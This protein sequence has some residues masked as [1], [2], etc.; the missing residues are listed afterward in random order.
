MFRPFKKHIRWGCAGFL[1][2]MLSS[3]TVLADDGGD[4]APTGR[5]LYIGLFGGGGGSSIN[6][7]TQLGNALF[8]PSAGG[9]LDVHATGRSN[10]SGVGL[11]GL[12]IGHEWSGGAQPGC[13]GWSPAVEVEGYYLAG[14]QRALLDNGNPRLPVHDFDDSF[15]MD[16]AVLLTNVVLNFQTPMRNLSPYIGGGIGTTCVSISGANSPQVNPPEPGVNHFNS[17]TDS[18]AWGFSAQAKIGVRFNLT[19]HIFLFTEYR[20]LYVGSTTYVFGSTQYPTH[21]PTT[22]WT[23][24]FGDM[25]NHLGVGGIG[26]KF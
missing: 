11:V 5:G 7:V 14:T 6:S 3:S 22:P 24:R 2:L 9:P 21:A 19:D 12:Q 23:V 25:N 26:F 15:P 18:S 1:L 10:N 4:C 20:Y 13:W 17:G 8:P 16:N